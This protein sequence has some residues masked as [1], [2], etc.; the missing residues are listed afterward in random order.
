MHLSKLY[1]ETATSEVPS[2]GFLDFIFNPKKKTNNLKAAARAADYMGKGQTYYEEMASAFVPTTLQYGIP[3]DYVRDADHA[4]DEYARRDPTLMHVGLYGYDPDGTAAEWATQALEGDQAKRLANVGRIHYGKF[5]KDA[6]RDLLMPGYYDAQGNMV[7]PRESSALQEI[8]NTVD[9]DAPYQEY[10]PGLVQLTEQQLQD[11][12]VTLTERMKRDMQLRPDKYM[13]K[14][15]PQEKAINYIELL[16]DPANKDL[17]DAF[18]V[19]MNLTPELV[20]TDDLDVLKPL[21][22]LYSASAYN[23]GF[24]DPDIELPMIGLEQKF[25]YSPERDP[26]QQISNL[27]RLYRG[28]YESDAEKTPMQTLEQRLSTRNNYVAPER[29]GSQAFQSMSQRPIYGQPPPIAP[30]EAPRIVA[31]ANKIGRRLGLNQ[32]Q[33]DKYNAQRMA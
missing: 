15:A 27:K 7:R 29:R 26:T 1:S 25:E 12:G 16:K 22:E 33:V 19:S 5:G 32:R 6:G 2:F 24:M 3:V 14:A 9:P 31:E 4:F 23:Q 30:S 20:G 28:A 18:Q 8:L 10:E 21:F 11:K 17:L 13:R